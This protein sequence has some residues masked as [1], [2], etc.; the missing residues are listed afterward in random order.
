MLL[1]LL[2]ILLDEEEVDENVTTYSNRQQ[3]ENIKDLD[4][5]IQQEVEEFW[6]EISEDLGELCRDWHELKNMVKEVTENVRDTLGN[7]VDSLNPTRYLSFLHSDQDQLQL[8]DHLFAY[9][10]GY[11]HHGLY[12]GEN[13]VIHYENGSVHH[14]SL[15]DFS[16][17]PEVFILPKAESPLRYE[18]DLVVERAKSRLGENNY[19]LIYNN[20]EHFVRWCRCGR[21]L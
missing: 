19:H 9:R 4:L 5:E 14:D 7:H 10:L 6:A 2:D 8:A 3:K 11:T 18:A 15:D 17:N 13:K 21:E 20:C 16:K 1:E 12:V